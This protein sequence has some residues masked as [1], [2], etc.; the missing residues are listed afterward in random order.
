MLLHLAPK[1]I[2]PWSKLSYRVVDVTIAE[3]GLQLVGGEHIGTCRPLPDRS[4]LICRRLIG[5]K[6][7]SGILVCTDKR[8]DSFTVTTRW[9]V[10]AQDLLIHHVTYQILDQ[11]Y[12]AITD[13]VTL[14]HGG[15]HD[16]LAL[17]NRCPE[18]YAEVPPTS[19]SPHMS[20]I[21]SFRSGHYEDRFNADGTITERREYF[22]VPT[23]ERRRLRMQ[24]QPPEGMPSYSEAFQVSLVRPAAPLSLP[25][26][27]DRGK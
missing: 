2:T 9:A 14:W 1:L 19:V 12:S 21:P 15:G 13:D 27:V 24:K 16:G 20:I 8:I 17:A 6:P 5:N 23:I 3:L 22:R 10:H 18:D 25:G 11:D 7:R 26:L 4:I